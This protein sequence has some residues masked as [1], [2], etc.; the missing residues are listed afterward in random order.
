PPTMTAKSTD[1]STGLVV[2]VGDSTNPVQ[3]ILTTLTDGKLVT[4]SF[5]GSGVGVLKVGSVS[6]EDNYLLNLVNVPIEGRFDLVLE[7][8]RERLTGYVLV[9][10]CLDIKNWEYI[11]YMARMLHEKYAAP[12]FMITLNLAQSPIFSTDVV[13]DR[14]Q[15]DASVPVIDVPRI[16]A[17]T[18]L[19]IL[20]KQLSLSPPTV[21]VEKFP[22]HVMDA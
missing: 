13:K 3:S 15:L 4:R 19:T 11:G 20:E 16:T 6:L 2:F 8:Y 12:F 17:P 9:V 18:I 1:P 14:L 22:L 7:S 21:I 5:N 10:D